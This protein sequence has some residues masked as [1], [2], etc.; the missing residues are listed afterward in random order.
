VRLLWVKAPLLLLRRHPPVLAA[1]LV[2]TALA[3]LA[4]AAVPLVRA[5]VES[6]SLAGQLRSISPLAAGFEIE[7]FDTPPTGAAGRRAAA[8]RL[9]RSTRFLGPP[10]VSSLLP[11]QVDGSAS[12]GLAVVALTRTGAVEHV[13]H[14]ARVS[15][16]GV[17]IADTTAKL[18]G[19]RPG[20][21]LRLAVFATGVSR[22]VQLRIAGVYRSLEGDRDN[23]Y[24]ANWLQD[25]RDPDPNNPPPPA[26]VLMSPAQFER[27]ART[28]LARGNAGPLRL[29]SIQS[30]YEL[31]VDP[32]HLSFADARR[33]AERFDRLSSGLLR[34]GDTFGRAL[35]CRPGTCSTSSSLDAA[36]TVAAREVAAV[37]PTISLLSGIGIAVALAL[38]AAA[39]FFVVRRRADEVHVLFARGEAPAVFAARTGVEA[40]LPALGGGAAGLG[41]AVL[42]LRSLAPSGTVTAETVATGAWRAAAAV[43]AAAACVAAGAGAAFPRRTALGEGRARH[44]LRVPWEAAPLVAAAT[45]LA[46]VL[47]GQGLAADAGGAS[48]P[49]LA[50]F[51][52]PV[53]AVAGL[54]GV[55]VRLGRLLLG[56]RGTT[57]TPPVFLALR[58]LAAARGLLVAVVVATATSFGTFAY[59]ATL[60]ASLDRSAAEKAY[61][62]NGSDVQGVVDPAVRPSERFPF[63]TALVEVDQTNVSLP[64]GAAV[65]LVAGDPRALARTLRWGDGWANDPR[66]LLPRLTGG[67]S[68]ELRAIATPG[69]PRLDAVVDQGARIPVR[70]VGHAAVPG[71]SAG[72]PALLVSR[73]AL[74]RLAR[75]LR[76]LDPAPGA[77]GLVWAKGDPRRLVP[78][79]ERS[80]LAPVYLTGVDHIR[81]DPSVAAAERSY[82]YVELI[83]TA[84]AALALVALLLYLQ[85]RQRSQLIASALARRMGLPLRGDVAALALEAGAVVLFAGVVGAAVATASAIPI[86]HHVD[87]LP[88]YAPAPVTVVPWPT[89]G[90]G[91]VAALGASLLLGAGAALLASR[92][93]VA[94]ALRVA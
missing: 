18:T 36:L 92:S 5:G 19:L 14:V 32:R 47:A 53:L 61:V 1:V 17:W 11:V 3:A 43:A 48:H 39:G 91:L 57:A 58:R 82:R 23:P 15:G 93:D 41:V 52:V 50:V 20:G 77:T 26:F 27:V 33:L 8:A 81:D 42:A 40:V 10:V 66:P 4:A 83:G 21:T 49:R 84:A 51:V 37:S 6:E 87:S 16:R 62:G 88:Q 31:P 69:M 22:V 38:G 73:V 12:P 74:H 79:L 44:L 35:R 56:R 78:V 86:A 89:L 85:A 90:I 59:A 68:A 70:V 28:L 25:I 45:L 9:A 65:D 29:P 54:A 80:S 75:R 34:P 76:I 46:L 55:A 2:T 64:S 67:G 13:G 60:S 72:R 30:R 24:W 71:S 7:V 94:E 63:P